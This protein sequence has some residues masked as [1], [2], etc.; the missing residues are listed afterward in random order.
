MCGGHYTST[1]IL[2]FTGY[3]CGQEAFLCSCVG[4]CLPVEGG[5]KNC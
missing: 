5:G 1:Y 2:V 4:V 3:F